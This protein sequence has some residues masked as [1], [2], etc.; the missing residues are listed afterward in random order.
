MDGKPKE[1]CLV[2]WIIH[3]SLHHW[4]NVNGYEADDHSK[5]NEVFKKCGWLDC[6]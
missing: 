2:G 1:L 6:D 5:H 4:T 3:E